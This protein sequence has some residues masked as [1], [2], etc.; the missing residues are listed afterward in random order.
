MIGEEIRRECTHSSVQGSN[1]AKKLC[2]EIWVW[3]HRANK[4]NLSRG[5][6]KVIQFRIRL[7]RPCSSKSVTVD[8]T[9]VIVLCFNKI[10]AFDLSRKKNMKVNSISANGK[11]QRDLVIIM[12][13]FLT[14]SI[15]DMATFIISGVRRTVAPLQGGHNGL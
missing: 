12:V 13:Q 4:F 7:I 1:L 14:F 2:E 6:N 3:C 15:L 9:K 10:R 5:Q 11:N 8:L